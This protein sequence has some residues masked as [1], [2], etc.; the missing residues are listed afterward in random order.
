MWCIVIT[1]VGGGK[2]RWTLSMP[3]P[4]GFGVCDSNDRALQAAMAL[5]DRVS[6]VRY[7]PRLVSSTRVAGGFHNVYQLERA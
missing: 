5:C 4:L 2:M 1:P 6:D 7:E 3:S